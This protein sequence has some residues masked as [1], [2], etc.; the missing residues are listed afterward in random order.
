MAATNKRLLIF[1]SRW[2]KSMYTLQEKTR[3]ICYIRFPCQSMYAS[4]TLPAG[5]PYMWQPFT[6]HQQHWRDPTAPEKKC[7]R[8]NPQRGWVICRSAT[9]FLSQHNHWSS[10]ESQTSVNSRLLHLP[11]PY[12][13]HAINTFNTCSWLP[14]PRSLTDIG[15]GYHMETSE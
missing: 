14:A 12:H 5:S 9:Q 3:S 8:H 6:C 15:G 1:E 2:F 11:G 4:R 13:W 10:N 7:S